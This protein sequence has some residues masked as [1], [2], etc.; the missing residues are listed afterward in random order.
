LNFPIKILS[1][2]NQPPARHG[3][4]PKLSTLA[5]LLIYLALSFAFFDRKVNWSGYYFGSWND[6]LLFIWCLHWWPFAI[7]HGLNPFICKYV[8]APAGYNLTWATSIP[9]LALVSA[10]LTMLGSPALSYN[11]LMLSAPAFAAWTAFLL[12]RELTQ[13]WAA[14]LVCGFLFGFSAPELYLMM[15]QLN[16]N[17]VFLIPLAALLCLRHIRGSLNRRPF[18]VLFS[19]VLAAQLGVSTEMLAA[20]CLI[21]A[22]TWVI[23]L[24]FAPANERKAYWRL[25]VDIAISALL[26][27]LLAAPF[28]YYLV[29][30]LPDFPANIHPVYFQL[31]D[32][33][34]LIFPALP[35]VSAG[36]ALRSILNQFS[37][38]T[39][40]H[41]A[42]LSIPILL[43]LALY[44]CR[45]IGAAYVKA[46]LVS[47]CVTATLSF[48]L[49]L[50]INSV[51][52]NIPLPW[53][54][55][56]HVPIV[57]N[58]SPYRFLSFLTLGTAITAALWLAAAKT[59]ASRLPR[60]ALAGLA[61]VLL[62]PAK[63]LVL[64]AP[65]QIQPIFQPHLELQWSRWPAQPFFTPAH[66][67]QALG[68]MPNVILLPDPVYGPGMAWQ[69]NAGSS[70]TQ[71]QGYIGYTTIH[72]QKWTVLD[73]LAWGPIKPDFA[74]ALP[75]FCAAHGVNYILIGP[76][77]PGSAVNAI[78]SLGW[79][80]HVD[81]GI[82]VVK[83]PAG[84]Q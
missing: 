7:S 14:S 77:T 79:P 72:E 43:I 34:K 13:D 25:A 55:F 27:M 80:R 60:Y 46:L 69:L 40:D 28:L 19:C 3:F 17:S 76:G 59:T 52:T 37:G 74:T 35:I 57:R 48:G 71:A 62:P 73:D 41:Y 30:G 6:A 16:L 78:E 56:A 4:A 68:P 21:G 63:V 39:P 9:F 84:L 42:N 29:K 38:F 65:W 20:L 24:L 8:W 67:R 33:L 81:D 36:A 54:L 44:F 18:I 49:K 53:L 51:F 10:P 23:F 26:A 50:Y 58:I 22:L 15:N 12:A 66:I 45:H 83:V 32:P 31:I 82:E 1:G 75:A 2:S 11:V 70:F 64:R 47:I 61:C 5:P